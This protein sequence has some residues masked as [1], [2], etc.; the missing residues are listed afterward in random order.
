MHSIL[1]ELG[2]WW[3]RVLISFRII[4]FLQQ[5]VQGLEGWMTQLAFQ[6]GYIG[7][8][9]ISLLG[10]IPEVNEKIDY[11]NLRFVVTEMERF[12]IETVRVSREM[13]NADE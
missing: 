2:A 11:M 7:I 1:Y 9:I 3:L 4:E 13:I 12:K 8:F 6:Y 5:F 10:H